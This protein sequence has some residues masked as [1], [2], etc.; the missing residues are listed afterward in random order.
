[1]ITSN[2]NPP[3]KRFEIEK[4]KSD[5]ARRMNGDFTPQELKRFKEAEETYQIIIKRN[6]GKN[7]LFGR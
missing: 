4:F 1:M 5:I 6:G 7:P 3:M 2:P